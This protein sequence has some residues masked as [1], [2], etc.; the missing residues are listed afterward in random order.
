[1]KTPMDSSTDFVR[2]WTF[3][4]LGDNLTFSDARGTTTYTY[5][6]AGLLAEQVDP[7]PRTTELSYQSRAA[8]GFVYPTG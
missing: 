8:I 4:R 2:N 6:A 1:M 7:R 3:D 5:N